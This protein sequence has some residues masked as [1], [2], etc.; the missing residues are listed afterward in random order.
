MFSALSPRGQQGAAPDSILLPVAEGHV[1]NQNAGVVRN[2]RACESRHIR[3]EIPPRIRV[4]CGRPSPHD[5]CR[6]CAV[7]NETA[8]GRNHSETVQTRPAN[9]S[10]AVHLRAIAGEQ[11]VQIHLGEVTARGDGRQSRR[12]LRVVSENRECRAN[13]RRAQRRAIREMEINLVNLYSSYKDEKE[14]HS[15]ADVGVRPT[16]ALRAVLAADCA[17]TATATL[18]R[19]L[20][21]RP[22][23]VRIALRAAAAGAAAPKAITR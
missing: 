13:A 20:P 10:L 11:E 7:R 22:R 5:V 18:V 3:F 12:I 4:R 21:I 23:A 1:E 9:G 17:D 19:M 8:F 6:D 16:T 2:V 15:A 14:D